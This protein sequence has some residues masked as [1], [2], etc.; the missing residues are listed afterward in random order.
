MWRP[1][2]SS[3]ARRRRRATLPV[4][5]FLFL[6]AQFGERGARLVV[7]RCHQLDVRAV[8]AN[9]PSIGKLHRQEWPR[10]AQTLAKA[11][12]LSSSRG[13]CNRR[14]RRWPPRFRRHHRARLANA[15]EARGGVTRI[16]AAAADPDALEEDAGRIL[17]PVADLAVGLEAVRADDQL[18]M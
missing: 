2:R 1:V 3:A 13:P 16:T 5:Q 9:E 4:Q 17:G 11:P 10:R 6:V 12:R 18:E 8:D 14:R 7:V 15:F